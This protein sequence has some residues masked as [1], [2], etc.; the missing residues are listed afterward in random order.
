RA[1][2][3]NTR[4]NFDGVLTYAPGPQGKA[5]WSY[6]QVF[7][8]G[9]IE[10]V[11]AVTLTRSGQGANTIPSQGLERSQIEAL[12][13]YLDLLRDL[14]VA[15]P[16]VVATSYL[17]VRD[18]E[19][20]VNPRFFGSGYSIDRDDLIVSETLVED[21]TQPADVLLRPQLDALWNALG[22]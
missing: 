7:R 17:D 22:Y 8:S 19:I 14:R 9:A 12:A 15:P 1:N 3:W 20:A 16:V 13:M 21:L 18:F 6:T 2:G 10:G 4:V 5:P 11:D